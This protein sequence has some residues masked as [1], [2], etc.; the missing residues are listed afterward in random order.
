M[1]ISISKVSG[2]KVLGYL[3]TSCVIYTGGAP[4]MN[5]LADAPAE[6]TNYFIDI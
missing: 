1:Y 4:G 2:D 3:I 6:I 5:P